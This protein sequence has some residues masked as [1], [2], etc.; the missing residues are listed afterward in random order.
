MKMTPR[1]RLED[2]AV[3]NG[4]EFTPVVSNVAGI[5]YSSDKTY[6]RCDCDRGSTSP[7]CAVAEPKETQRDINIYAIAA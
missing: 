2:V 1:F 6:Q 3:S 4:R 5:V 7:G